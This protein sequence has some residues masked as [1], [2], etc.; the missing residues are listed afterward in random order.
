MNIQM[1]LSLL[2]EMRQFRAREHWTRKLLEEHQAHALSQVRAYA[3][4][5][6]PFYQHFHKG[7]Y[8]AP[9]QDLPVLTKALLMEHFD[10]VVTDRAIHLQ[11]VKAHAADLSG[12]ERF[13]GH[14]WVNATSGSSGHPGLFLFNRT[15]WLTVLASFARAR[16]W[17]GIEVNLTRRV[18][19]ATIAST[20]PFHISAGLSAN[21]V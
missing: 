6:S 19:T 8:D 18:K 9:L 14:Y 11:E 10:E 4:A 16:E 1:V 21:E 5:H 15:E 2:S 20:T 3:Y 17:A 12:D 13:L 7:L